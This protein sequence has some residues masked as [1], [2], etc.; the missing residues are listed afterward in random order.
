MG[1]VQYLTNKRT[2]AQCVAQFLQKN[3]KKI[4]YAP[5]L[6]AHEIITG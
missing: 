6:A 4:S 2:I 5:P 1:F 3:W